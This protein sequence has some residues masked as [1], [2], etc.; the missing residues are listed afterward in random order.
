MTGDDR[1]LNGRCVRWPTDDE[2]FAVIASAARQGDRQI[3]LALRM[4]DIDPESAEGAYPGHRRIAALTGLH[5]SYVRTR[6]AE[7]AKTGVI[8]A[9]QHG[10]RAH[11][12]I[13]PLDKC[14]SPTP[15]T[16]PASSKADMSSLEIARHRATPEADMSSLGLAPNLQSPGLAQTPDV[17]AMCKRRASSRAARKGKGNNTSWITPFWDVWVQ[18]YGGDPAAG[19][20]AKSLKP[21]VERHG[22]EEVL[23][24]WKSYLSATDACYNPQPH[25]FAS[26]FASWEPK[27]EPM[28]ALGVPDPIHVSSR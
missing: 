11:Y 21:L 14:A 19:P 28:S 17:Q 25:K 20:L 2:F 22:T 3:L 1:R 15:C 5:P 8:V 10:R 16:S 23:R 4:H 12:F 26:T 18:Q 6:L 9:E 7:L 13:R 27:P 24:H